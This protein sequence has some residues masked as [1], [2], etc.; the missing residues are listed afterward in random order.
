AM[1]HENPGTIPYFSLP[2]Q[3]TNQNQNALNAM[4]NPGW[5]FIT[6]KGVY[7]GLWLQDKNAATFGGT[8]QNAESW[9]TNPTTNPDKIYL[10]KAAYFRGMGRTSGDVEEIFRKFGEQ[11]YTPF[12]TEYINALVPGWYGVGSKKDVPKEACFVGHCGK[13]FVW[14]CPENMEELSKFTLAIL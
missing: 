3:G 12:R 2:I 5:D 11:Y 14:V 4:Y 10:L 9:Q 6:T 1:M 8:T 13:T 7:I